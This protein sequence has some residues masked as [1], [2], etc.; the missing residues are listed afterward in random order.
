MFAKSLSRAARPTSSL[1]SPSATVLRCSTASLGAAS[2][3]MFPRRH[4]ERPTSSKASCPP[5]DRRDP[6]QAARNVAR[7]PDG[8]TVDGE[9]RRAESQTPTD[10]SEP[11]VSEEN[12]LG[13]ST[14]TLSPPRFSRR[15][16]RE[17]AT[18]GAR[19]ARDEKFS[20]PPAVPSTQHLHLAGMWFS[21][22]SANKT[23]SSQVHQITNC[24][25]Q[26]DVA[27]SSLFAL[28]RPISVTTAFPPQ[29]SNS[30]FFNSIFESRP[31]L[32]RMNDTVYTINNTISAL[33]GSNVRSS[34]GHSK[35]GRSLRWEILQQSSSNADDANITHL[36]GLPAGQSLEDL[37]RQLQ[38]FNKPPV[39]V[40]FDEAEAAV[41]AKAEAEETENT[42]E[43]NS[44]ITQ[45][46]F[47][48][49]LTIEESTSRN[50]SKTY[51]ASA[52]PFIEHPGG[53]APRRRRSSLAVMTRRQGREP[54]MP[55][56]PAG[57]QESDE[58]S[59][60]ERTE[61]T[62]SLLSVK[63]QRKL[64]MKKHKYKKLMKRTRTLRRK[65]GRL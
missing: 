10:P 29:S 33:E 41:A 4:Q 6:N 58:Q 25:F 51:T 23:I 45:K 1:P 47:T 39:P 22:L 42:Q 13:S 49:T 56:T 43:E 30:S 31:Q 61:R 65:E 48:T 19:K 35:E 54:L 24:V 44:N 52:S 62:M 40:P 36:D 63:R 64:K 21:Y 34:A 15:K 7:T 20:N 53:A 50:G 38:P 5:G 8:K 46:T 3:P 55:R 60:K 12:P 37:V 32:S 18:D 11:S 27:I 59:G 28:H 14:P 17:A 9:E 57:Q 26:T 2:G 16:V